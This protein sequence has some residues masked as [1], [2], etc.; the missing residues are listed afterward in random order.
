VSVSYAE[1]YSAPS[2][3]DDVFGVNQI[4]FALSGLKPEYAKLVYF[5]LKL[6]IFNEE[7]D[8]TRSQMLLFGIKRPNLN[9]R[10]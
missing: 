3:I 7:I 4:P 6:L 8:S 9:I 1:W 10:P 2:G 5:A